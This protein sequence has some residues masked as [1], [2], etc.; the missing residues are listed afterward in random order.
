MNEFDQHES[1]FRRLVQGLPFTDTAPPEVRERLRAQVLAKFDE[2]RSAERSRP[3]LL[4]AYLKGRDLMRRPIP[5]L[6]AASV[7]LAAIAFW[8]FAPGQQTAA[9]AFQNF[10]DAIVKAKS[11]RFDMEITIEGQPKKTGQ[12]WFQAPSQY[13]QEIDQSV[14]VSDLAV[15]KMMTLIPAEKRVVVINIKGT[16][17]DMAKSNNF[18]KMRR[19]LADERN[20]DEKKF[21]KLGEKE[22]DGKK[23]IGFQLDS[24]MGKVTLWGDPQT[25]YPVRIETAFSGP[26]ATHVVMTHFQMNVELKPA[27][28]D[29]TPPAGYKVR[30]L[31]V[32]GAP[33]TETDIVSAFKAC[34]DMADVFPDTIDTLG[35]TKLIANYTAQQLPKDG[36]KQPSDEHMQKLMSLTFTVGRGFQFIIQLP[37]EAEATYAG[38]GVKHGAKNTPIFWYKPASSNRYRVLDAE[39]A[40]HDRE[41]A[42]QVAGAQRI[43]KK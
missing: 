38:K 12:T 18:E 40:F 8:L 6:I 16:P 35:I 7:C 21:E 13:R 27:L 36:A 39:L 42:P 26:P 20:A 41:T 33:P 2:A 25:S 9:Y 23:A 4:S 22:I 11:A 29:M 31:D 15:G 30:A 24:P 10:A 37:P 32:D 1:E 5:R 14:N 34:S 28:F 19:L 17:K 3:W 43:S